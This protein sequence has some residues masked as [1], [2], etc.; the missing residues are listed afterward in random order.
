MPIF[1]KNMK[2]RAVETFYRPLGV[3]FSLALILVIL[4]FP[5]AIMVSTSL[6]SLEEIYSGNPHWIPESWLFS[7][8]V[9]VWHKIPLADYFLNSL[10]ISTGSTLLTVLLSLPAAYALSRLRFPG[11][12]S[13]MY[14]LLI[15]QMFSPIVIIISL[16]KVMAFLDLIDSPYSLI[17]V[18]MVFTLTFSTWLMSGY[19][20]TIPKELEEAARIDG[21]NRLTAL[22]WVI[23]PIAR[24][25]VVTIIIFSFI[26]AWNEFMFAF[27]FIS[28]PENMPLTSG[29]FRFVGKFSIQWHYLMASSILAIVPVVLLFLYIEK[30][31]VSGLA[32]GAVKG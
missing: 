28:T 19:F 29:L 17:Y 10:F 4:L 25:G 18:N 31:L 12:K 3:Y 14:L 26:T 30:N 8:F 13:M 6:K 32:G 5:F 16:F 9:E 27:T 24:P 22:I 23:L 21:C 20:S 1:I 11:R 7:N 15:V 2:N